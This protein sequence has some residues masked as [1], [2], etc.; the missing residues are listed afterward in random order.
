MSVESFDSK[1]PARNLSMNVDAGQVEQTSRCC[2]R[3]VEETLNAMLDA[4]ADTLC[5]AKRYERRDE[6]VDDR[7]GQLQA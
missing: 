4:E 7:A 3:Y 5:G 2:S 1:R 6:R